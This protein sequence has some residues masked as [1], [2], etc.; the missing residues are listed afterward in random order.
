M[1]VTFSFFPFFFPPPS[2][3]TNEV[4]TR[5]G[6]H[7]TGGHECNHRHRKV[8]AILPWL[9]SSCTHLYPSL[10]HSN[11]HHL[12]LHPSPLSLFPHTLTHALTT[13]VFLGSVG[14]PFSIGGGVLTPARARLLGG[15]NPEGSGYPCLE[16]TWR[17]PHFPHRRTGNRGGLY[18]DS[19]GS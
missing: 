5:Q 11:N 3:K 13:Y 14:E 2:S 7:Q 1:C 17:Y 9:S 8:L 6:G 15:R 4:D 18:E 12:S 16:G 10:A 19:T